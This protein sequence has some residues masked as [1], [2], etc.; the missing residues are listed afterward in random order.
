VADVGYQR[1]G[2]PR[3]RSRSW[4]RKQVLGC[5][6]HPA[7]KKAELNENYQPRKIIRAQETKGQQKKRKKKPKKKNKKTKREKT[8]KK[9]K[10]KKKKK[11]EKKKK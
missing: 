7:A 4:F 8:E 10:K 5:R 6:R 3:C 11:K 9:K 1:D 2:L